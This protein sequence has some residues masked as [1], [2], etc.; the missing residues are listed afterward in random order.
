M[1]KIDPTDE[2]MAAL[3]HEM[4]TPIQSI[5][6]ICELLQKEPDQPLSAIQEKLKSM[7]KGCQT[8]L[9]L[10]DESVSASRLTTTPVS[11]P[12]RHILSL[13][14]LGT[15]LREQLNPL[16]LNEQ[17][18]LELYLDDALPATI[19]THPVWVEQIL[20]NL[21]T[22]ALRHGNGTIQLSFESDPEG[23]RMSVTDEGPGIPPEMHQEI[24]K[25]RVRLSG[26]SSP[27][28][29]PGMGLGLS[30]ALS[31]TRRLGGTLRVESEPGK[32]STF[33]L[34]L[35]LTD[36]TTIRSS[37]DSETHPFLVREEQPPI[38]RS[39]SLR[40]RS[41]AGA[42]VLIVDD[43]ELQTEALQEYLSTPGATILTAHHVHEAINI[44]SRHSVDAI[45]LD[46]NLPDRSGIE[47]IRHLRTHTHH[48]TTPIILYSGEILG[49]E[50]NRI[51]A[52]MVQRIR[53][54]KIG[55]HRLILED[56]QE[57]LTP[58]RESANVPI[59]PN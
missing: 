48:H 35:P 16:M 57:L 53:K 51:I 52:P 23:I 32:G 18:D 10:L 29:S 40:N 41:I 21:L 34:T 44:L 25:P 6:L 33:Q 20:R 56:L 11:Y 47:L 13:R 12:V 54:K 55:S 45:I 27:E 42:T 43:S 24:F 8:L 19:H 58:E 28:S 7:R 59:P 46:L 2:R 22:N 50:T 5:D 14:D 26:P 39:P 36:S 31:W 15:Y 9:H 37:V 3:A 38:H 17:R 49:R 1:Q 4:R 30:L